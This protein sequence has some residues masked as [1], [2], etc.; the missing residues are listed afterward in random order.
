MVY[1]ICLKLDPIAS[2]SII[3][4]VSA[5]LVLDHDPL[6]LIIDA[7]LELL[8]DLLHICAHDCLGNFELFRYLSYYLLKYFPAV[9]QTRLH[10]LMLLGLFVELCRPQLVE[11]AVKDHV[12]DLISLLVI[13]LRLL[14]K[15]HGLI[16]AKGCW[17]IHHLVP[18]NH[19]SIEQSSLSEHV[20]SNVISKGS[21]I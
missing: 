15:C 11:E 2:G 20:L 3:R 7:L 6:L 9:A 13:Y 17:P 19:L 21:S 5:R 1:I 12:A 14:L 10:E 16:V 8:K 18:H 4:V